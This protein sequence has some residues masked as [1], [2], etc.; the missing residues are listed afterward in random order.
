MGAVFLAVLAVAYP[1]FA[2]TA[3]R[4][5]AVFVLPPLLTAVL[6]GWRPTAVVGLASLVVAVVHGLAGPLTAE[7]LMYRWMIVAGGGAMGAIGARLRQGQ[8]DRL[9]VLDEAM[10][11]RQAFE[12]ALAPAPVAPPGFAAV[13][14]YRAAEEHMLIGGDF[15]EAVALP[16]GRLAVLIGDICGHGPREA[17]FGAAVRAG[18]KSIAL[19][20]KSD[21]AEWV[22]ALDA[23]FF[24]DGRIDA[25][26]TMCT[27]YLD[28]EA[29]VTRLV[30][31]GHP[32]PVVLEPSARALELPPQPPLG[33][34]LADSWS[35]VDVPWGGDPVLFYTDGL[36]ENPCVDGPARRWGVEGLVDWL[37]GHRIDVSADGLTT[38]LAG[39]TVERELRDDIALLLVGATRARAGVT[40]P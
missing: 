12:R 37:N 29:H 7:P 6:G 20:G 40:T 16:D 5:L 22:E 31:L 27:G 38:L 19:G 26:A 28:L 11:L 14:R 15:L 3:A 23:A 13:S 35:A 39:A 18:W 8:S 21:P 17:A 4:P 32:P 30:N 10:S 1:V 2:A 9:A 34:G 25:Y 33:L 36:I 24:R